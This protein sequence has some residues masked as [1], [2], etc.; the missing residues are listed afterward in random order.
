MSLLV[1]GYA[2][3]D[4]KGFNLEEVVIKLLDGC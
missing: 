1:P 2:P 4:L 3:C